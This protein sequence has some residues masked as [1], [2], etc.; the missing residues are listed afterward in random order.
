MSVRVIEAPDGY[1]AL[2]CSTSMWA[3]G[4][5]LHPDEDPFEFLNWLAR[6]AREYTDSELEKKYYEW[7]TVNDIQLHGGKP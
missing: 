6:D 4:P 7:R 2:Y 5:V 3:F 1:K